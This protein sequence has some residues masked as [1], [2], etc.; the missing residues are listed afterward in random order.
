MF[1]ELI[2]KYIAGFPPVSVL[3]LLPLILYPAVCMRNVDTGRLASRVSG[4]GNSIAIKK[5]KTVTKVFSW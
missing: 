4:I 2:W 1:K 5:R 3:M